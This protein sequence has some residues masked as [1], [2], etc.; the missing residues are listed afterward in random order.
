MIR[1]PRSLSLLL[2]AL[3]A[4]AQILS[5]PGARAQNIETVAEREIA[6]R[7]A[8]LPQGNEAL[9]RAKVSMQSGDYLR[10][11]EDYRLAV[12]YLPDAAVSGSGRAEAVRGFAESGVKV[13]ERR[14]QE[15]KYSE[16]EAI[17]RDI[18]SDQ[19]DPNYRPA[20]LLLTRLREP[21]QIN[22]TMGPK[23]IEKVEEVRRLLTDADGY[24][25][26]GRYDLAFK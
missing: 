12:T 8:G 10:A 23:F 15:G 16:A 25:N 2:P 22:R 13:A 17:C 9:A 20:L 19:Y 1:S 14:V 7:Q 21:G 6:R 18:L 26:S 4:A 11:Y 3:V 24:Y 5:S